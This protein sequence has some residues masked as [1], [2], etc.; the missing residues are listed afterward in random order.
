VASGGGKSGKGSSSSTG[1]SS[2][3]LVKRGAAGT[4]GGSAGGG[5]GVSLN[6]LRKRGASAF[7]DLPGWGGGHRR[8]GD[9]PLSG[10]EAR[11]E[12]MQVTV[13]ATPLLSALESDDLHTTALLLA[14]GLVDPNVRM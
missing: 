4:S 11:A 7:A 8:L 13:E 12:E 3:A 14:T 9:A 2:T 6:A 1:G 10:D 5:A